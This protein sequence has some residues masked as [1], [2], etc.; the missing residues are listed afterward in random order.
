M[1]I[2][3]RDKMKKIVGLSL[4]V[5]ALTTFFTR[6]DITSLIA[7]VSMMLCGTVLLVEGDE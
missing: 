4:I 7:G 6:M 5:L 3:R 2:I 1:A